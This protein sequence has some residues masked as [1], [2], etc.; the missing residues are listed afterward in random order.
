MSAALIRAALRSALVV[1]VS[2]LVGCV[3]PPHT[4]SARLGPFFRPTNVSADASLG[5]IRRVVVLPLWAGEVT[6]AETAAS[7]DPIL[8]TSLAQQHRF[9]VVTLSR[10]DCQRRYGAE[11]LSGARALPHDLFATLQREFAADA[12]LFV[13][14][15]SFEPYP[16]LR[17]GLR[18][19]LASIDGAKLVWTFDEVFSAESPAVANSARHFFLDRDKTIPADLTAAVL[20]SPSRFA[21]YATATMFSTL[22]PVTSPAPKV[23]K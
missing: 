16:P 12:V 13:D 11:A 22:P 17:L 2:G 20:Q 8:L 9:E 1:V 7:L 21:A 14:L 4:D 3:Y 18:A 10:A 19:K 5:G 15:T 23:S 6:S